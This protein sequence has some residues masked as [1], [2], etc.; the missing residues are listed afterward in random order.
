VL[1]QLL[2]QQRLQPGGL[3]QR[4]PPCRD[5]LQAQ[6]DSREL[7]YEHLLL[8]LALHLLLLWLLLRLCCWCL[9][10]LLPGRGGQ[11]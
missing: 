5:I 11:P 4:Y 6:H 7:L 3:L 1:L 8:S 10:C 2:Q 9:S